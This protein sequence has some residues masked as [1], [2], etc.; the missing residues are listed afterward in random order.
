MSCFWTLERT[1]ILGHLN[2][3]TAGTSTETTPYLMAGRPEFL[4]VKGKASLELTNQ[5][6]ESELNPVIL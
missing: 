1:A 4:K 5:K 3:R 6:P 2:W